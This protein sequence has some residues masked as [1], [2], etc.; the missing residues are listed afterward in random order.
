MP[1]AALVPPIQPTEPPCHH[2]DVHHIDMLF[3]SLELR[4]ELVTLKYEAHLFRPTGAGVA[5][6]PNQN[7]V[8]KD[9]ASADQRK[10]EVP[11]SK[12]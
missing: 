8:H 9:M 12:C 2:Q 3:G 5:R 7:Q 6:K 1:A 4:S 11:A 10:P